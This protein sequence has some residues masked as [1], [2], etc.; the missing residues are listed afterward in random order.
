M[1]SRGAIALVKQLKSAGFRLISRYE[2]IL[3]WP[4]RC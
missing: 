3:P 4:S 2:Y 1:I